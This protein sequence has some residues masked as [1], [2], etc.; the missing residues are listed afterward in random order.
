MLNLMVSLDD[1]LFKILYSHAFGWSSVSLSKISFKFIM[2]F[3]YYEA[4]FK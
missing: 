2:P 3:F 4:T 1:I